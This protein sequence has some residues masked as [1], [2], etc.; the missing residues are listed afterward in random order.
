MDKKDIK[1]LTFICDRMINVYGENE[2]YDYMIAF[3]EIIDRQQLTLPVFSNALLSVP[4]LMDKHPEINRK[5]AENLLM[6]CKEH[7]IR[8][9]ECYG[10]GSIMYTKWL[11]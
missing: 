6:F 3:S 1:I 8:H 11:G 4:Y 2:S 5:Q 10:D 7:T 9:K